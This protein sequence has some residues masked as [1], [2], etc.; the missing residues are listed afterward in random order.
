MRYITGG[1]AVLALIV[2]GCGTKQAAVSEAP[3]ATAT[4]PPSAQRFQT[5]VALKDAAVAAGLPCSTWVQD[6]M[7]QSAAES[8]NCAEDT[9]LSTYATDDDLQ[10]AIDTLRALD[11]LMTEQKLKPDPRL[12]GPNWIINGPMA[13]R[14]AVQLGGTVDR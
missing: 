8:G 1:A 4:S 7:V 9:V 10:T 5:V 13:D 14:F 11:E 3:S 12:I 2:T 6:N